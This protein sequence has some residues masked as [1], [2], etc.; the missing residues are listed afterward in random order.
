MLT[1]FWPGHASPERGRGRATSERRRGVQAHVARAPRCFPTSTHCAAG[2]TVSP[3]C[4]P[5]I[6][7]TSLGR[8]VV[9]TG[10]PPW[11]A[12]RQRGL[13]ARRHRL[14]SNHLS[15]LR[16][17][18]TVLI[19]LRVRPGFRPYVRRDRPVPAG[20]APARAG[21]GRDRL[22]AKTAKSGD[23]SVKFLS[24]VIVAPR[25]VQFLNSVGSF[26]QKSRSRRERACW[27]SLLARGHVARGPFQS[28]G[29]LVAVG[30]FPL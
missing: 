16:C 6:S 21:D 5:T 1:S 11:R 13:G 29:R 30:P 14:P 2:F 28:L 12:V 22:T 24:C 17:G 25:V 20:A 7:I 19:G 4:S 3:F 27:A 8:R 9:R 10:A 26:L 23:C 15:G 18:P